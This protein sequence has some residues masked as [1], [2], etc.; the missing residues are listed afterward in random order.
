MLQSNA[1]SGQVGIFPSHVHT[2]N[3]VF[4][5]PD[6]NHVANEV[7]RVS[8]AD[9]RTRICADYMHAYNYTHRRGLCTYNGKLDMQQNGGLNQN[10]LTI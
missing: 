6:L 8:R 10:T 1:I 9:I 4:T 7:R 2:L 5:P 3:G